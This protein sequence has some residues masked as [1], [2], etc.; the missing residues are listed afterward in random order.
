MHDLAIPSVFN[1]LQFRSLRSLNRKNFRSHKL[2]A[3][4]RLSF[5]RRTN[6]NETAV[7]TGH[8]SADQDDALFGTDLHDSKV[9]HRYSFIAHVTRHTHIFPDAA[10]GGTIADG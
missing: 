10:R 4:L 5:N 8:R 2:L 3:S 9:L 1:N 6:D 7:R